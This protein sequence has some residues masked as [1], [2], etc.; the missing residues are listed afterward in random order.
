M[1]KLASRLWRDAHGAGAAE[2]ALVLPLFLVL[3]FGIIDAGRFMWA[4]NQAEKA[5][6][7]GARIAI[8]TTA[9]SPD[10]ITADYAGPSLAAGELIPASALGRF[11]CTSTGCTCSVSPCPV[12]SGSVDSTAFTTVLVSRM[13]EIMPELSAANVQ[14]S[15][16]GSGFGF[17]GSP[18]GGGPGGGG[19]S[20]P[21]EAMEISPL[22][23]VTI[24]DVMFKPLTTLLLAEIE[25][26]P[27]STTL[28]AEDVS[29][30][31]SN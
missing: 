25:L 9:V 18:V 12:T 21:P 5:T 14:V 1:S 16:S 24:T 13:A 7:V 26:P 27:F 30:V 20:S 10:L 6:Q 22:V 23:T 31:Y 3:L 19:G 2:F 11:T 15:Y 17:A 8:V 4:V 28:P 29:G